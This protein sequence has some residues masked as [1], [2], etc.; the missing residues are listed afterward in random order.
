MS[1]NTWGS[2]KPAKYI[3]DKKTLH[4]NY[5]HLYNDFLG[6]KEMQIWPSFGNGYYVSNME[7]SQ[8]KETLE[9]E[10]ARK[11]LP[12]TV[13]KRTQALVKSVNEDNNNVVLFAKMKK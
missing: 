3:V 13:R 7:P 5:F 9:K 8:L 6:T 2:T 4:G 10:L 11:D 12:S 1:K